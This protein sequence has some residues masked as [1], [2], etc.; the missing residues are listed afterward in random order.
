M[1]RKLLTMVVSIM[2]MLV[3]SISIVGC[4]NGGTPTETIDLFDYVNTVTACFEENS[5][6][7][8]E[9]QE[10]ALTLSREELILEPTELVYY[11]NQGDAE[12][13]TKTHDFFVKQSA[14]G[15]LQFK[16]V[17]EDYFAYA[18]LKGTLVSETPTVSSAD[19]LEILTT[20]VSRELEYRLGVISGDTPTYYI[21]C[22]NVVVDANDPDNCETSFTYKT[23]DTK[24]EYLSALDDV[25]Y[26]FAEHESAVLLSISE[27]NTLGLVLNFPGIESS[28]KQQILGG[29]MLDSNLAFVP[30]FIADYVNFTKTGNEYASSIQSNLELVPPIHGDFIFNT[31]LTDKQLISTTA[32]Y[33]MSSFTNP[34]T[35]TKSNLT[36]QINFNQKVNFNALTSLEGYVLD[37]GLNTDQ[38]FSAYDLI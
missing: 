27:K 21:S 10:K 36:Q 5:K 13:V 11:E 25:Y 30:L 17:G 23:F 20:N 32:I 38:F 14:N 16:K 19:T 34:N 28:N 15:T 4:K 18:N 8:N 12:M 6:S 7:Q 37:T 2:L 24:Q 3:L 29:T 31:R 1:K 22:K 26:L 33:E 35:I 9:Y